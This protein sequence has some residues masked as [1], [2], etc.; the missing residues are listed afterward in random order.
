MASVGNPY[1][2]AKAESFFRT[3]KLEEVYLKDYRDFEEAEAEHR[4]VHRGGLQREEIALQPR[5]SAPGRIRGATCPEGRK[6]TMGTVRKMGFT[7]TPTPSSRRSRNHSSS[8]PPPTRPQGKAKDDTHPCSLAAPLPAPS[9]CPLYAP[10]E[11]S[12][13]VFVT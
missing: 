6:L 3:L 10:S 13:H 2:N 4:R 5:V 7:P 11:N 1:E 9:P 12:I 8:W